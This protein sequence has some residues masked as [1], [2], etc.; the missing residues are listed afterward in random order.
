M[1]LKRSLTVVLQN[2]GPP[3]SRCCVSTSTK[4]VLACTRVRER[5]I[6]KFESAPSSS[7]PP[8]LLIFRL[9]STAC[10]KSTPIISIVSSSSTFAKIVLFIFTFFFLLFVPSTAELSKAATNVLG[11]YPCSLAGSERTS[12]R[13]HVAKDEEGAKVGRH[14]RKKVEGRRG[15]PDRVPIKLLAAINHVTLWR[16]KEAKHT[17]AARVLPPWEKT[18]R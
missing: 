17:I 7:L 10:L 9:T 15:L 12:R 14:I 2:R 16:E 5:N 8:R 6:E 4:C 11:I 3:G 1:R 18:D 13:V